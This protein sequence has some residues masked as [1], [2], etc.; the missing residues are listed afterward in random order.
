MVPPRS[1]AL[2][3]E[4]EKELVVTSPPGAQVTPAVR[5]VQDWRPDSG[6]PPKRTEPA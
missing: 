5:L 1:N 2:V 6:P 3:P 4:T